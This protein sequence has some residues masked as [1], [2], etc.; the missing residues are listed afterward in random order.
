M[1]K[2]RYFIVNFLIFTT[3]SAQSGDLELGIQYFEKREPDLVNVQLSRAHLLKAVETESDDRLIKAVE[4]YSHLAYYEGALVKADGDIDE[5]KEIFNGCLNVIEK[6]SPESFQ[7][8]LPAYYYWKTNCYLQLLYTEYTFSMLPSIALFFRTIDRGLELFGNSDYANGG[9]LR[10]AAESYS[11]FPWLDF[12]GRFRPR[13]AMGWI[14]RAQRMESGDKR[15]IENIVVEAKAMQGNYHAFGNKKWL[16]LGRK[17]LGFFSP[18]TG[19][20]YPLLLEQAKVLHGSIKA[21]KPLPKSSF[22]LETILSTGVAM[23][24]IAVACR[25]FFNSH[26]KPD[27]G[28][29]SP[30][31]SQSNHADRFRFTVA[32]LRANLESDD[33][34][35][36]PLLKIHDAMKKLQALN[37]GTH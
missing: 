7:E 24:S 6:I 23:A 15:S 36:E 32:F 22:S 10:I 1:G 30:D 25:Y 12:I 35:V 8:E 31:V 5:R 29:H 18:G 27:Y 37:S 19:P 3:L 9:I 26:K 21:T 17:I 4:A 34:A 20:D 11:A 14:K 13:K 28:F 2:F 16:S 33:R